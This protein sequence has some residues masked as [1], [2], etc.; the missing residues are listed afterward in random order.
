MARRSELAVRLALG[1]GPMRLAQQCLAESLVLSLAG[2][3][4]GVIAATAGTRALL[5]VDAGHLPRT[6]GV[7]MDGLVLAFAL[8]IALTVA[9]ALALVTAWRATRADVRETLAASERVASGAG[10]AAQARR[11]LVVAQVAMT[12][13]LLIGAGLLGRSLLKLL[14]VDPG[15]RI[16]RRVVLDLAIEAKDSV[17]I[18]QRAAFYHEL[19]AR[20]GTIPGVTAVGAVNA[21]PLDPGG[22]SSGT[23]IEMASADE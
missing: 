18:I 21:I 23:F 4:L 16:E 22:V 12:I 1:A 9:V 6:E 19:L 11:T 17:P 2:G 3:V 13:V 14:A 10:S 8:G 5:S 7:R 20:F 15:F